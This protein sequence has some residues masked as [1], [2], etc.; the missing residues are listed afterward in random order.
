MMLVA[1]IGCLLVGGSSSVQARQFL[2]ETYYVPA[3]ERVV[4]SS[5]LVAT[6]YVPTTI[7]SPT[8]FVY[9]S[10]ASVL[11]PAGYSVRTNYGLFGRVRSY[12]VSPT[13]Y[14]PT[15]YVVSRPT[16]LAAPTSY[17]VS[18]PTY[19]A[20][21]TYVTT[22]RVYER[23]YVVPTREYIV[24]DYVV[25]SS[26][27]IYDDSVI[28]ES[29]PVAPPATRPQVQ[30]APRRQ[31]NVSAEPELS[32][33]GTETQASGVA[34]QPGGGVIESTP[35][36]EGANPPIPQAIHEP[37]NPVDGSPPAPELP[38]P[39][40]GDFSADPGLAPPAE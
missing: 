37:E 6:S 2:T 38:R 34:A 33:E 31:G 29:E 30:P 21:T 9:E 40:Q 25:P 19:L 1:G 27:V 24:D 7:L 18:R 14:A 5:P 10:T 36:G 17:V 15:S 12:D 4:V 28:Y 26:R 23:R 16:Y 13:Y 32:L 35:G 22:P 20:P 3:A 39:G 11:A 8:R